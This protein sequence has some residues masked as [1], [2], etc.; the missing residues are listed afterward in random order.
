MIAALDDSTFR[1]VATGAPASVSRT[2]LKS[3]GSSRLPFP[4]SAPRKLGIDGV[5]R[6]VGGGSTVKVPNT[7][8]A[9]QLAKSQAR[10]GW[11]SSNTRTT[12]SVAAPTCLS[13]RISAGPT[14]PPAAIPLVSGTSNWSASHASGPQRMGRI[15]VG[16]TAT[17]VVGPSA[18]RKRRV[19]WLGSIAPGNAKP[20]F[21]R[22]QARS[23]RTVTVSPG[24]AIGR[25]T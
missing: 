16:A 19:T 12:S 7:G 15:E 4:S 9:S 21:G 1:I 18:G 6:T 3:M 8:S 14:S 20:G 25:S 13:T 10:V 2:W 11:N 23:A 5:V 24:P 17:S 22:P